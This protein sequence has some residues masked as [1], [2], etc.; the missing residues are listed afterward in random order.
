MERNR[1]QHD[2]F[3]LPLEKYGDLG[4]D[5]KVVFFFSYK[6]STFVEIYNRKL[7]RAGKMALTT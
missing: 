4:R 2:D 6:S 5:N 1:G 3:W 7:L